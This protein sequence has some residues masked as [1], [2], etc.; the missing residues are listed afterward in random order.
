MTDDADSDGSRPGFL[1]EAA[2]RVQK[3]TRGNTRVTVA[4]RVVHWHKS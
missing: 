2:F 3:R 4:K 1:G